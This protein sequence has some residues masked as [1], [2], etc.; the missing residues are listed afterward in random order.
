[1]TEQKELEPPTMGA[2]GVHPDHAIA[3]ESEKPLRP[4]YED[5]ISIDIID[6]LK[7]FC[8]EFSNLVVPPT[9]G[10]R[11]TLTDEDMEQSQTINML[12]SLN[13]VIY[14]LSDN[15]NQSIVRIEELTSAGNGLST[16]LV[17]C[18]STVTDKLEIR[19]Q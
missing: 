4:K 3:I 11:Q 6:G 1:M 2:N 9:D 12:D 10:E 17:S 16:S 14:Q 8:D 5:V 18:G 15:L 13:N 19:I 7:E